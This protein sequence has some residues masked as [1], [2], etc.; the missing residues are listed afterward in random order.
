MGA[1]PLAEQWRTCLPVQETQKT[2]VHS[3]S[4]EDPLEKEMEPTPVVLPGESSWTEEAGWLQSMGSQRV[5]HDWGTGHRERMSVPISQFSPALVRP[6]VLIW[7]AGALW[8]SSE[9]LLER[10]QGG[11]SGEEAPDTLPGWLFVTRPEVPVCQPPAFSLCLTPGSCRDRAAP[12][13]P[14]S[15]AGSP[16][17][18]CAQAR[19]HTRT[20]THTASTGYNFLS[21]S[22][23]FISK[24]TS[25]F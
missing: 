16:W 14:L 7:K 25:S 18:S 6:G 24:H 19:A 3:L 17:P 9:E 12:W 8:F 13:A 1:S 11:S 10:T 21:A 2:W 4:R 23:S 20:H 22:S 15:E 5:S